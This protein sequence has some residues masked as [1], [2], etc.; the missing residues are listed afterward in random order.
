MKLPGGARTFSYDSPSATV[1]AAAMNCVFAILGT[2][3]FT[4]RSNTVRGDGGFFALW[5][6][7]VIILSM[8]DCTV[9]DLSLADPSRLLVFLDASCAVGGCAGSLAG[10]VEATWWYVRGW[11]RRLGAA[12]ETHRRVRRCIR[13]VSGP[14][15]RTEQNGRL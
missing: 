11:R 14:E 8:Y 1:S 3:V 4:V 5:A 7:A 10:F 2:A 6:W 13:R 15:G 9:R 12:C